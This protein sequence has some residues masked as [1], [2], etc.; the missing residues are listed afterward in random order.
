ML[1]S[2]AEHPAWPC[3]ARIRAAIRLGDQLEV[4][5]F[6]YQPEVVLSE[7]VFRGRPTAVRLAVGLAFRGETMIE[8]LQPLDDAPSPFSEF[9]AAGDEGLQHFGFWPDDLDAAAQQ[10][11]DRGLELDYLVQRTGSRP[12]LFFRAPPG[13]G[14]MIELIEGGAAKRASYGPI[15]AL[16]RAWRPGDDAWQKA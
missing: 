10:C 13:T 7:A 11:R 1:K 2:R 15:R 6:V 12:T 9:L 4:G 8:L 16:A 3:R 14:A 5:P